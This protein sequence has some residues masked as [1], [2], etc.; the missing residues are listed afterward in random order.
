MPPDATPSPPSGRMQLPP[1]AIVG[2]VYTIEH[3]GHVWRRVL[4]AGDVAGGYLHPE[5]WGYAGLGPARVLADVDVADSMDDARR[6]AFLHEVCARVRAILRERFALDD[7]PPYA[8]TLQL[9]TLAAARHD[10]LRKRCDQLDQDRRDNAPRWSGPTQEDYLAL[11]RIAEDLQDQADYVE[12][13]VRRW[14]IEA[15]GD[16][17]D[18]PDQSDTH[19]PEPPHELQVHDLSGD[20]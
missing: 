12:S 10:S 1:G 13:V 7:V 2:E 3:G 6:A 11:N 14:E 19:E 17:D 18:Y 20:T 16:P 4:D 5:S 9:L 15:D 8:N